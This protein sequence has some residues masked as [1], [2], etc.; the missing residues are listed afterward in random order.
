[1]SSGCTP[2]QG[3]GPFS[4]G[5][6]LEVHF[7]Q[8]RRIDG[9]LQVIQNLLVLQLGEGV[10]LIDGSLSRSLNRAA[11]APLTNQRRRAG[12]AHWRSGSVVLGACA[13]TLG[14]SMVVDREEAAVFSDPAV[15]WLGVRHRVFVFEPRSVAS[16]RCS[17]SRR[18][19]KPTR[20]TCRA[21]QQSGACWL[22]NVNST[23]LEALSSR[24]HG[25]GEGFAPTAAAGA[26]R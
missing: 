17:A 8:G 24:D 1:M 3:V 15:Y 9:E 10:S 13:D 23:S 5:P 2:G 14:S 4:A 12:E 21:R 25:S 11:A 18:T 22:E 6:F 20:L 19:R 7:Q 16:T 26:C